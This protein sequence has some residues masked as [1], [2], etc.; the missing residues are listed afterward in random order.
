MMLAATRLIALHKN[1]GMTVAACLSGAV[2]G[3]HISPISD[4]TIL[5]SAGAQCHH[6]DHVSTQLPY[7]LL[8]AAMSFVGFLVG[9]VTG[10]G[11]IALIVGLVLLALT[12]FVISAKHKKAAN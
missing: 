6:I 3:D 8:V 11:V 10:S 4:T 12:I 9:G 7:A 5:A 2:C 1:K